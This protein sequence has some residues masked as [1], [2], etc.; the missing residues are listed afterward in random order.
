MPIGI[1]VQGG[2]LRH[3]TLES[4]SSNEAFE[5]L[6]QIRSHLSHPGRDSGV[7]TLHN[8]T[9]TDTEMT[10][11]RKS[12]FQ[13]LFQKDDRLDD[14]VHAMKTLLKQAGKDEAVA[15]LEEYLKSQDGKKNRIE[16]SKMSE[17]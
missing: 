7:L 3:Q 10:L 12:S 17:S 15:E 11:E 4:I 14:T 2:S 13:L 1:G 5:S 9:S 8:R 16:S 6:Q